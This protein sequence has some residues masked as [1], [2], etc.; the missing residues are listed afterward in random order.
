MR[1]TRSW[2]IICFLHQAISHDAKRL[3]KQTLPSPTMLL[4]PSLHNTACYPSLAPET[5]TPS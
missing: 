5:G 2:R 4:H 1:R 3:A